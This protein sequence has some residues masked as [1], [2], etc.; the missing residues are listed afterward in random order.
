MSRR[1]AMLCLLPLCVEYEID[2]IPLFLFF[3]TLEFLVPGCHPL[4]N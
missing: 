3:Y 2:S 4:D 1:D